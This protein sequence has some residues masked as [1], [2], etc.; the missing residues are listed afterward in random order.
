MIMLSCSKWMIFEAFDAVYS[1]AR[2][3]RTA[4]VLTDRSRDKSSKSIR[5]LL[6]MRSSNVP[7]AGL[8]EHET[9]S[10]KRHSLSDD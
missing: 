5:S 8:Q 6:W 2:C 9:M 1:T 3:K 7:P 4:G 10:G